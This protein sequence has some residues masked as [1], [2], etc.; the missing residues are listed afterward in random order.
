M[1]STALKQMVGN[2]PGMVGID[3]DLFH[4]WGPETVTKRM[5]VV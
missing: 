1:P 4:R 5:L 3:A 2:T